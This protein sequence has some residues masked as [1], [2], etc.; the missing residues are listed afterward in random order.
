MRQNDE[1]KS[2]RKYKILE[3]SEISEIKATENFYDYSM[4]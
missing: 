1:I 2:C 3:N 4:E